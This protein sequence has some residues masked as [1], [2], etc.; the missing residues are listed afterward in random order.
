MAAMDW[1]QIHRSGVSLCTTTQDNQPDLSPWNVNG[2]VVVKNTFIDLQDS[3]PAE[4]A[5]RRARSEP[6][7]AGFGRTRICSMYELMRNMA[8]ARSAEEA[9]A[10]A[11]KGPCDDNDD[12]RSNAAMSTA[13]TGTGTCKTSL[14]EDGSDAA[15]VKS[16]DSSSIKGT[17]ECMKDLKDVETIK[18]TVMLRNLPD[19]LTRDGL[20]DL[21]NREGFKGRYDYVYLPQHFALHTTFGYAFINMVT[22]QEADRFW[23]HF[24]GFDRWPQPSSKVA[25]VG[26]SDALQGLEEQVERYRNS[27]IMHE[28]MPDALKPAIFVNGVRV[29]FPP[30]TKALRPP[31]QRPAQKRRGA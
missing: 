24:A 4:P 11:A 6:R 18:T 10:E 30:P 20:A 2:L 31:R 29:P 7:P 13:S 8:E 21:L 5:A 3:A 14:L 22:E 28:S 9:V 25:T 15:E 12:A 27:R 16:C 19:D 17:E 23:A 26:W 1:H